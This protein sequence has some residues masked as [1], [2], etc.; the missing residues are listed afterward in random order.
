[1]EG[2]VGGAGHFGTTGDTAATA[3]A[4]EHAAKKAAIS[5]FI[6]ADPRRPAVLGT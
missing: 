2:I 6:E 5:S 1:V 3:D 4:A